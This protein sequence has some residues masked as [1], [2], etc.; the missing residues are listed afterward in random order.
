MSEKLH[1]VLVLVCST[2]LGAIGQFAFK[3]SFKFP[4]YKLPIFAF[5][6]AAYGLSTVLY[7][8]VLSRIH[9]SWAY[10]MGGLSYIFV[11]IFAAF[12]EPVPLF[13]VIGTLVIA[14]GVFLIGL[15]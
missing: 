11:M 1:N 14:C 10:S 5:G 8:Y 6:I 2:F 3:Y 13:R 7:F 4:L 15:S 12:I 9:L